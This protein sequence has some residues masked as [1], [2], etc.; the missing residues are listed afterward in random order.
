MSLFHCIRTAE[1]QKSTVTA[2]FSY[3]NREMKVN[4]AVCC[5]HS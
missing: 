4:K 3:D 2:A 1:Y 5:V